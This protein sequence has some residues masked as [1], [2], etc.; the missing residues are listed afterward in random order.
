MS[1]QCGLGGVTRLLHRHLERSVYLLIK[2]HLSHFFLVPTLKVLL[3]LR[4]LHHHV[5]HVVEKALLW[6]IHHDLLTYL[7]RWRILL[8]VGEL[9]IP[10]GSWRFLIGRVRVSLGLCHVEELWRVDTHAGVG[11][12]H[13]WLIDDSN[14]LVERKRVHILLLS[15]TFVPLNLAVQVGL[16]PGLSHDAVVVIQGLVTQVIVISLWIQLW[17]LVRIIVGSCASPCCHVMEKRVL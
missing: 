17:W 2:G 3:A 16:K 14:T 10:H 11:L 4:V 13:H 1:I 15:L 8:H 9:R 7:V 12:A 6:R 5:L